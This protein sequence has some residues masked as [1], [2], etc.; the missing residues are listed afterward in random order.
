[1]QT[2]LANAANPL[3]RNP[4]VDLQNGQIV[5]TGEHERRNAAGRVSGTVTLR[6]VVA[7]GTLSI[8]VISASIEGFELSDERITQF[9]GALATALTGRARQ[10]N[11]RAILDQVTVTAD[12]MT[13][14][15]LVQVRN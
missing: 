14:Q 8:Q 6:P 7:N 9:N 12:T 2:A 10:E 15:I 13:I 3:L 11:P 5:I 1:V 4:S